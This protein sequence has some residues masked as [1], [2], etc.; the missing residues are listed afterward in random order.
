MKIPGSVVDAKLNSKTHLLNSSSLQIV[1]IFCCCNI[2]HSKSDAVVQIFLNAD[3]IQFSLP[4]TDF[5]PRF[6]TDCLGIR[7]YD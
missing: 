2:F 5:D 4:N 1:Q 7:I 6:G 3:M